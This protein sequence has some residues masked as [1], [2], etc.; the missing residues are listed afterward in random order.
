MTVPLKWDVPE[1]M[2]TLNPEENMI[3]LKMGCDMIKETRNIVAGL[4]Q[5][6]IY[7]K[8]R[9]ETKEDIKKLEIDLIV[10]REMKTKE[11]ETLT[12][13]YDKN[14]EHL[15]KQIDYLNKQIEQLNKQ[16]CFYEMERKTIFQDEVLKLKEKYD[17]LLGEKDKQNELN[18]EVFNKA[19]RL[20]DKTQYKSSKA[21]GDDGEDIFSS[22]A[23][24]FK[25]FK[26]FKIENKS[27]QGHKGDF[28]LFF[29]EFNVLVDAKN[30]KTSIQSKEIKKIEQDLLINDTMNF[31]WLVS[32]ESNISEWNRYPI[33]NKWISTDNG[34]KCIIFINNLLSNKEPQDILRVVWNICNEFN[35]LVSNTN[36]TS[37]ET[38]KIKERD[39]LLNKQIKL[40]QDR[41][42]ELKRGVNN[43]LKVIKDVEN[44]LIEMLSLLSNEIMIE[45]Y[46]KSDIIKKWWDDNIIYLENTE[47]V[48]LSSEIW[49][50]FKRDN[51]E[52]IDSNKID[53]DKFKQTITTFIDPSRYCERT[54]KGAIEFIGYRLCTNKVIEVV[55]E[56]KI[57]KIKKKSTDYYFD[58]IKDYKI[59]E[60]YE[61][62][63]NDIM[64]ISEIMNIRPWEVISLLVKHKV[65][66]A[67]NDARGF[68]I[69]KDTDEYK[70]KLQKGQDNI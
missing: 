4:S 10:E 28:H 37:Y 9:E 12:K 53:I 16:V 5:K 57:K 39:V 18:R 6:E 64:N 40:T 67:R 2:T 42:A 22:L 46:N 35:K 25:D 62:E 56:K 11:C 58:E 3:I 45:E 52:Y 38:T 50:A 27:K 66:N 59:L 54:K 30:Y 23:E 36:I 20:L 13:A 7:E 70:I 51:K 24:T 41:I 49:N 68:D 44:G 55:T 21:K 17:I 8:I 60:L 32:L 26:G 15:N 29:D 33:M 48:L 14:V 19:E 65:V 61:D 47:E 1:I 31:A 43:S 34:M 69:Y 63:N